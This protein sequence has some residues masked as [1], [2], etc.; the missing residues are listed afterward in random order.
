[1]RRVLLLLAVA[2]LDIV[3]FPVAEA[4]DATVTLA[5]RATPA[6]LSVAPGTRVTFSNQ[7]GE[8]RGVRSE[9]GPAGF[10]SGNLEAGA[11]WSLILDVA[12]TYPY[13]DDRDRDDT[14]YHGT[15]TVGAA[16]EPPSAPATA[17][18]DILDRSF[19]PTSVTVAPG[20]TVT[21]ANQSDRDHTVTG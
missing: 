18:V 16:T 4:S 10:D 14:A 1:M 21:W 3:W 19:S 2:L 20:A 8:R 7:S 12:G 6:S 5:D 11:S 15:I 17:S 9:D 13:V